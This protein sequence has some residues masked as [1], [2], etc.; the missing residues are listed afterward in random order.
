MGHGVTAG[1]APALPPKASV[2]PP[3]RASAIVRGDGALK[4]V[5]TV[6]DDQASLS[7]R[8]QL[9]KQVGLGGPVSRAK[10][11]HDHAL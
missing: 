5:G 10:G 8:P 4:A 6:D 1:L 3:H 9:L 11:F 2:S 7:C